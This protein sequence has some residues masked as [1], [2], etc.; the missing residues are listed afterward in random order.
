MTG[1]DGSGGAGFNSTSAG[2][3]GAMTSGGSA[4]A[5]GS[6]V[7]GPGG[8]S[9]AGSGGTPIIDQPRPGCGLPAAAFFENFYAPAVLRGRGGELEPGPGGGARLAHML[10]SGR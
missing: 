6:A 3:G 4:G 10:P 9:K 5:S 2:A 7:A 8:S 1:G